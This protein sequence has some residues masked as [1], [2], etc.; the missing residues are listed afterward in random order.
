MLRYVIALGALAAVAAPAA[1]QV[2]STRYGVGRGTGRSANSYSYSITSKEGWLGIGVS[3]SRCSLTANDDGQARQWTFSE[4]PTVFTVDQ[5]GPADRA[6]LRNGDTLVAIDGVPL[7]SSRGGTAFANIRPGQAVRLTYR[8]DG[9]ERQVHLVAQSHPVTYQV[10]AAMQAMKRAQELQEH[11][12]ESS[13]EQLERSR[14]TLAQVREQMLQQL[15]EAQSQRDSAS[16]EQIERLRSIL[17]EQQRV[18]ARTLAERATLEAREW[19]EAAPVAALPATPAP[20]AEPA[21]PAVPAEPAPAALPAQP[22]MPAAPAIAPMPP[23]TYREHRRF[24]PLRYTGR[25][26]DVVI[27]ARG[28]GGVTATEVSDSEVVV[29]SG[30]L[31]VRLALRPRATPRPSAAPVARP[32]RD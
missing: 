24:G 31:S 4:P 29:T 15:E 7:T 14:A 2:D 11:T 27:E 1:A 20:G 6:G 26:G 9:E 23:M 17:D 22:A 28:P 25:L 16:V 3:C 21:V 18:L 30:D 8:R 32:P 13:R 12:L 19:P 10:G 5:D